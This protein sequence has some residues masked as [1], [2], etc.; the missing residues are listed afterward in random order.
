MIECWA[1]RFQSIKKSGIRASKRAA[2][3][4]CG[5]N[6]SLLL[7]GEEIPYEHISTAF[8]CLSSKKVTYT[9]P[10]S[11]RRTSISIDVGKDRFAYHRFENGDFEYTVNGALHCAT[12]P[13][14]RI[15][16]ADEYYRYGALHNELGP[17]VKTPKWQAFFL[18]GRDVSI[19]DFIEKSPKSTHSWG[20]RGDKSFTISKLKDLAVMRGV[21]GTVALLSA[22][23]GKSNID[24]LLLDIVGTRLHG[25]NVTS[26]AHVGTAILP[27][28]NYLNSDS[29]NWDISHELDSSNI[30]YEK[31]DGS[32]ALLSYSKI[33][34]NL[35]FYLRL[36]NDYE[37]SF[38]T[39]FSFNSERKST[40]VKTQFPNIEI[41]RNSDGRLHRID[42]LAVVIP[43]SSPSQPR[44]EGY[45]LYGTWLHKDEYER[46]DPITNSIS[47]K[48]ECGRYH[49]TDGPAI[50]D[51]SPHG[52][53][54]RYWFE[55]GKPLSGPIVME[56]I[57]LINLAGTTMPTYTNLNASQDL[58]QNKFEEA[59][60][61]VAKRA[62]ANKSGHGAEKMEIK[63]EKAGEANTSPSDSRLRQVASG[64]KLG[65][66]KAAL[67]IG[68]QKVA[69]KVVE[70][71][72]PTDNVVIQRIVQVALL[73]GTAEL[74]ERLPDGAASRVGL[75]EARREGYGSL[76]RYIAG[77]TLG[78]DVGDIASFVAPML[79]DKLQGVS[80]EDISELTFEA[81]AA[82][83]LE[84]QTTATLK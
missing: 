22:S 30:S 57:E 44:Y 2:R 54:N 45:F 73:L 80:A 81:E 15:G 11:Q 3:L 74:T 75:T 6:H 20:V 68:S 40:L 78:R 77:E 19:V 18:D 34:N 35:G 38:V 5:K 50:I 59:L 7:D 1:D 49:R 51:I 13:A 76:A 71:T 66:Q 17:A 62:V 23:D 82:E 47:F 58:R 60:K 37:R 21:D 27:I 41:H 70:L 83:K 33:T 65:L 56:K 31:S 55:S 72:S 43:E 39:D 25:Y 26:Y 52:E 53:A 42:G 12:G 46:F 69:E 64:A 4:A 8:E 61:R 32:S 84:A 29:G 79:L 24:D 9:R 48:D 16:D 36:P 28:Y 63:I 67:R 10:G 14:K